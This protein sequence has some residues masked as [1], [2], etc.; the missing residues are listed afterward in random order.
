MGKI[1]NYKCI[2]RKKKVKV[3]EKGNVNTKPVKEPRSA[4]FTHKSRMNHICSL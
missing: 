3:K 2:S 1:R 4:W